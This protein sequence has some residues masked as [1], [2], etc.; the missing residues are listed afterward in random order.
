MMNW[1]NTAE[2]YG[3]WQIGLHWVM[4]LLLAAVYALMEL[5][6]MFPKGSDANMA[7]KHW[8]Y[9]LGI[10]VLVLTVLR[11]AVRFS[12]PYPRIEPPLPAWQMRLSAAVHVL[13]YLF[14][15]GMPLA[16]WLIFSASDK[17]VPFFFGL[18]LPALIGEDEELF[19]RIK[20]VHETVAR[21]GY[22]LIGLHTVAA[23]FHHYWKRDN[24]LVRMLPRR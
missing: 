17:P 19:E 9:M 5:R 8:H 13:L 15:L 10:L 24:T 4:L 14:M 6:G 23:L 16:G 7:M 2:R 22:A 18:Q 21:I 1:R 11:L 3:I 20:E 12:M